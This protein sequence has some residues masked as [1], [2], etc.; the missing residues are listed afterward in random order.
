MAAFTFY[1]TA[2]W[3]KLRKYIISRDGGMCVYCGQRGDIAHHKIP[4]DE[5]NCNSPDIVWNTDNLECVCQDCHNRIHHGDPDNAACV[6]G[7]GFDADGN[8]IKISEDS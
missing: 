5:S 2:R 4:V 6:D 8:L 1:H 3:R 7:Y